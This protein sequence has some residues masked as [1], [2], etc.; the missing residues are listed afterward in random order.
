MG[1]KE[2]A[3]KEEER[4]GSEGGKERKGKDEAGEED[5]KEL[6][7]CERMSLR[8]GTPRLELYNLGKLH[9]LFHRFPVSSVQWID[10]S[11]MSGT[12]R[13]SK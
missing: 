5:G 8:P 2:E 7:D 3:I 9:F 6:T 1:R 13:F 10:G 4:R 12:Q 11:K